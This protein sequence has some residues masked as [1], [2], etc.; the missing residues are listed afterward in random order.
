MLDPRPAM[1]V[2]F[3]FSVRHVK[4]NASFE[5][6]SFCMVFNSLLFTISSVFFEKMVFARFS[7]KF[8]KVVKK[9]NILHFGKDPSG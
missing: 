9:G 1:Q 2:H 4:M 8:E 5:H 7:K 6:K 3:V